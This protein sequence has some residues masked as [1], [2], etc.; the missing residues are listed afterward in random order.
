MF[1]KRRD[2]SA[3]AF[4]QQQS[5]YLDGVNRASGL[6]RFKRRCRRCGEDYELADVGWRSPQRL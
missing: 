5:Q 4:S 3:I 6:S 2:D 1:E